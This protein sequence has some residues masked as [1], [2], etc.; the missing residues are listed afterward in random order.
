MEDVKGTWYTERMRGIKHGEHGKCVI[1]IDESLH[2]GVIVSMLYQRR[3]REQRH[4]R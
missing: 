4:G 2:D 3:L 1:G